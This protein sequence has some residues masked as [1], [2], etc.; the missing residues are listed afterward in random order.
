VWQPIINDVTICLNSRSYSTKTIAIGH[1]SRFI[2]LA[3]IA[4]FS[5]LDAVQG[6]G[7]PGKRDS[8]KS[9]ILNEKR[10][11][12][13][14]LPAKYKPGSADK[15]DVLYVLDG[16]WNTQLA[17]DM[18]NF[19]EGEAYMPPIIIVGV[20]N[21]DRGRDLKIVYLT[22]SIIDTKNPVSIPLELQY[23]RD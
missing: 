23:S 10:V 11:I 14:V 7:L 4:T 5:L 15:Y 13:V 3:A 21:V 12:Q 22:P 2:L 20:L 18:Q 6:Q 17:K 1:K 16:D 9:A 8:I 19:I